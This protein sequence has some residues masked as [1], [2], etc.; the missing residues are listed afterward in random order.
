MG[1]SSH[2]RLSR[3]TGLGAIPGLLVDDRRVQ[4]VVDL[5]LVPKPS[6]IVIGDGL[7][8]RIDERRVTEVN[9]AVHILNRMLKLGRSN[10]V[11]IS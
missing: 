1:N 11:R 6:D 7:R 2:L 10:Y 9:V 5:S 8:P 3:K 4:A